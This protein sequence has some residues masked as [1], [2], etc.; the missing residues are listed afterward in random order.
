MYRVI[1]D[2]VPAGKNRKDLLLVM[3][4][5]AGVVLGMVSATIPVH[6][7]AAVPATSSLCETGK[8]QS[9]VSIDR[10][11]EAVLDNLAFRQMDQL[12]PL[13]LASADGVAGFSAGNML[14]FNQVQFGLKKLFVRIPSEHRIKGK[15]FAMELQLAYKT[16]AGEDL[17]VSL[18]FDE[19]APNIYLQ[20]L[21]DTVQPGS[22]ESGFNPQ[23]LL[24]SYGA[25]FVYSGSLTEPPCSE[26]VYWLVQA[27]VRYASREQIE[28]LQQLLVHRPS[29]VTQPLYAR[30]VLK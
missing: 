11:V 14:R 5:Y 19:G 12:Q 21:L 4:L 23:S 8:N 15:Q 6:A 7:R 16:D 22:F 10:P 24:T 25:Y 26:G 30:L 9:P 20:T 18:L 2:P 1:V 13:T 17:F 28:R 3:L 29:R 27:A